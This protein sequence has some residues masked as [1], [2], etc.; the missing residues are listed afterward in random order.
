MFSR[1]Y[2]SWACIGFVLVTM[3][4]ATAVAAA[5]AVA[6]AGGMGQDCVAW[7]EVGSA[8]EN[9]RR[10]SQRDPGLLAGLA[11]TS[12]VRWTAGWL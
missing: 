11:A 12:P 5:V 9:M 2:R 1:S 4:I 3:P 8:S 7:I 10:G 6:V